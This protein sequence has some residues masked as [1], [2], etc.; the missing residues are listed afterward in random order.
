MASRMIQNNFGG[1]EISPTLFG[2]SDLQAYYKGCADAENF[3]V[4]KEGSLRKR[5]GIS[6]FAEL[7]AAFADCKIV[8]YKYDRTEGG[9]LMLYR[10][11]D[12]L[13]VEYWKKD[14]AKA[15]EAEAEGFAGEV[16]DI[17]AKQVGDQV[18]ISNGDFHKIVTISENESVA[19]KAWTQAAIP[20]EVA[21]ND[22]VNAA[23]T[24][25]SIRRS[26][27][28]TGKTLYYGVI[29]VKDSVNSD[30][31][32]G[33]CPWTTTWTAGHYVEIITTVAVED[34]KKWDCFLVAK[35]A[36]GTYG[37]LTRFYTDDTPEEH[38][39]TTGAGTLARAYKWADGK[40]YDK[41]ETETVTGQKEVEVTHHRFIFK[42]E[43]HTPGD[44]IYGQ[45]NVLGEG[46]ENPL[47]I[48]CFQQRR[49]FANATVNGGKYPM[50]LWFSETGNLDNFFSDRPSADDDA[51]SPTIASTGPAFIRWT[52]AYQEMM[53]LF[54]DSGLFSVGFSQ[55]AGFSASSCRIS[56]FSNLDVS[57]DIPP[58]V[59]DAG[60]VFVAGDN[61]TVYTASYDLQEN[62]LKPINRSVLVE[63]LT[64]TA[65]IRAIALQ[66]YPDNVVW[67]VTDDGKFCTF[68]FER[69]EEVYAWSHGRIEG[70]KVLDVVA[71][72]TCTDSGED[73][74]YGDLVFV[75]EGADGRQY[76]ARSNGG[77]ADDI[78]GA[79][80]NVRAR[81]VTLRPESQERTIV[82]YRK[83]VKDLLVRLYES[84]GI[85]V[86][87][88]SGG[89]MPI[90]PARMDGGLFTGDVKVMPRGCVNE[91][92]QM[93]FISDNAQ[94]CE[95]L[96]I[97]T[98]L[99]VE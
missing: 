51:F 95:I 48:D 73:R 41:A 72:G 29:A 31:S 60:V 91:A 45:T 52:L 43:N 33:D 97:V 8:A 15:G 44:A 75:V 9:V 99:E 64:R 58:V 11:G 39:Y 83:N 84:G 16:K 65:R 18:W 17:Q 63:H 37:E 20:D 46:F 78:G 57:P 68:T 92:G 10:S 54:T 66:Q 26:G 62:M 22:T 93:E 80:T 13:K 59:T 7:P 21:H 90:V 34:L 3:I 77:Y 2:R 61:K 27:G 38:C 36:G 87:S 23:S 28:G 55:Q 49:V 56:R 53:I 40:W 79:E 82:G 69:N 70:A 19:V 96:Q 12:A 88:T 94:P 14:G 4:A 32:K 42:D 25:W 85:A 6:T 5:H 71:P 81:L 89:D 50:T 76:L 74:T 35:R 98:S 67:A 24:H 47:C 1:G 30:T 86:R